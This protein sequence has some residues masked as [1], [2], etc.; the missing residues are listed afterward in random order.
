MHFFRQVLN[1]LGVKSSRKNAIIVGVDYAEYRLSKQLNSEGRYRVLFFINENPWNH[2]T[3]MDDAQLRYP[4]ELMALCENHSIE[5]VFY[6]DDER[7]KEL[8]DI[9]VPL[10]KRT[11]GQGERPG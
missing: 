8:P 9:N 2:L 5:A 3:T 4:S 1:K 7:V 10:I 11:A 6:T